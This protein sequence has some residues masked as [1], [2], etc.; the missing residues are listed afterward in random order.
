MTLPE[1]ASIIHYAAQHDLLSISD[2]LDWE[3]RVIAS[4]DP[5]SWL[6]DLTWT[7]ACNVRD[8]L[9][10]LRP[11]ATTLPLHT[12]VQI[13][14]LGYR[15]GRLPLRET[16]RRMHE[17]AFPYPIG[18]ALPTNYSL[19]EILQTWDFERDEKDIPPDM[20]KTLHYVFSNYLGDPTALAAVLP[21]AL[22]APHVFRVLSKGVIA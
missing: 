12:R 15:S 2:M 8:I 16:L 5:P 1:Q 3:C 20:L 21:D 11:H 18:E 4:G 13:T 22:F 6:L 14:L 17:F 7:S 19:I 9:H 10:E